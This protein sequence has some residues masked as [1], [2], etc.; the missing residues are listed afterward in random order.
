MK[1]ILTNGTELEPIIVTGNKKTV[2]GASRDV[3]SFIFG[4]DVSLDEMDRL[5]SV[6]NCE[7]I[8][9]IDGENEYV[10]NGYVIRA[11]LVRSP[12]VI[13]PATE[14][15]A[16]VTENRVTVSMGQRTYTESQIASLTETI[17]MLVMESLM[18]E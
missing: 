15:A 18:S 13:T 1:I 4:E 17:D 2:Q 7:T 8:T 10:Y 6:E 5:F 14:N 16:E 3:L 9:I 12:V 11:E